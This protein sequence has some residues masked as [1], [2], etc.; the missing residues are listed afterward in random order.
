[1]F[2][3]PQSIRSTSTV[4]FGAHVAVH[5]DAMKLRRHARAALLQAR[6]HGGVR[7]MKQNRRVESCGKAAGRLPVR[8]CGWISR[9][10]ALPRCAR[11]APSLNRRRSAWARVWS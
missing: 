3:F 8:S 10:F 2:D 4:V 5:G 1:M 6:A 11:S 9:H 7:V